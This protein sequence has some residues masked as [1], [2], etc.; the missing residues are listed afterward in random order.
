[1][2]PIPTPKFEEFLPISTQAPST[3]DST[4]SGGLCLPPAEALPAPPQWWRACES[5]RSSRRSRF[6]CKATNSARASGALSKHLGPCHTIPRPRRGGEGKAPG[7][8]RC[9]GGAEKNASS[10]DPRPGRGPARDSFGCE[11]S[12]WRAGGGISSERFGSSRRKKQRSRQT[13]RRSIADWLRCW[14][15]VFAGLGPL[16]TGVRIRR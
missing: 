1:M 5:C 8:L 10:F 16:R 12:A 6:I 4:G 7:H 9:A 2:K 14:S 3:A 15:W 13:C 11:A